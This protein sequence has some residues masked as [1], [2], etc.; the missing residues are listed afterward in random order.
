MTIPIPDDFAGRFGSATEAGRRALEGLVLVEY[1]AGRLSR[2]ELRELLNL[3]WYEAEGFLKAHGVIEC[4][5]IEEI[6]EQAE[7][8]RRLGV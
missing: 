2:A 6:E 7:T 3:G 4:F 1:R 8:L 5:T